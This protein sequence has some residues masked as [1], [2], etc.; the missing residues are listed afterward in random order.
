M[1]ISNPYKNIQLMNAYHQQ[2]AVLEYYY[3]EKDRIT[4]ILAN[5]QV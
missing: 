2:K 5:T 4:N 1:I 3:S